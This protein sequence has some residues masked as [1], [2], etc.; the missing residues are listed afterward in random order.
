MPE[1]IGNENRERWILK[2]ISNSTLVIGDIPNFP[3]LFPNQ[4][5][6]LL[7]ISDRQSIL[8][9]QV[10]I[11][12]LKANYVT[13]NKVDD[14]VYEAVP[15]V[16]PEPYLDSIEKAEVQA[17]TNA[18]SRTETDALLANKSNVGHTHVHTD[19]T[20]FHTAVQT[21]RLDQFA[22]PVIAV[23]MNNQNLSGLAEPTQ[24]KDAAT[25][26]YVDSK[27]SGI[28]PKASCVA[29][30]TPA[31]GNITLANLQTIDGVSL[32]DTNRILVKDQNDPKENG[33]YVVVNGGPWYRSLDTDTDA[34]ITGMYTFITGGTTN[35]NSGWTLDTPNPVIGVSD[36]T[37]TQFSATENI[38]AGNGLQK[39][40]STLNVVGT[41]DRIVANA[42][43]VDISPNYS[44]QG[45]IITVGEITTG[46][47]SGSPILIDHGGTGGTEK[48]SA[49]VGIGAIFNNV[50]EISDT[51]YITNDQ[52]GKIF[53]TDCTAGPITIYLP[54]S[55]TAGN[56]WLT[57]FRKSDATTNAIT[58]TV[59]I[60]S[61]DTINGTSSTT[62]TYQNQTAT[63]VANGGDK[64]FVMQRGQKTPTPIGEGGTGSNL[65]ATGGTG[66]F[67]KQESTGANVTVD[68]IKNTE[69]PSNIDSAKIA[70]GT[71][72]NTEFQYINSLSSNAQTQ[73]NAKIEATNNL[74]SVQ[75]VIMVKKNPGTGEYSSIA[76]AITYSLTLTP[77]ES[78]PVVIFIGPGTYTEPALIIPDHVYLRGHSL[79]SVIIEPNASN[80]HVIDLQNAGGISFLT[81]KNAGSGYAGIHSHDA[82][83]FVLIHKVSIQNCDIGVQH[84]SDTQDSFLFL[85]YVDFTD[86]TTNTI[87]VKNLGSKTAFVNC[88]NLY[89][90][91]TTTDPADAI[92]IDGNMAEMNIQGCSAIGASVTGN[93]VRI[94]NGGYL[95]LTSA[96]IE[97]WG[98][99]FIIDDTAGSPYLKVQAADLDDNTYDIYVDHLTAL[100]YYAGVSDY[101][102]IYIKNGSTYFISGQENQTITVAKSGGQ[103]T[104]IKAAITSITDATTSKRYMIDVGPGIYTEDTITMKPYV[105]IYGRSYLATII[106]PTSVNQ[107][108]IIA[109]GNSYINKCL[110]RGTT[111]TNYS[112]IKFTTSGTFRVFDC[113]FGSSY[114]L[115]NQSFSGGGSNACS[116]IINRVSAETGLGSNICFNVASNGTANSVVLSLTD[117]Y[118]E[119]RGPSPFT[120][121][122]KATGTV[123]TVTMSGVSAFKSDNTGTGLWINNGATLICGE[124]LLRGFAKA[125]YSE[126]SGSAPSVQI[127]NI[128]LLVNTADIDIEHTGTTGSIFGTVD[129]DKCTIDSDTV[130]LLFLDPLHNGIYSVGSLY[131]GA[132]INQITDFL[133]IFENSASLGVLVGG[134]LSAGAGLTLNVTAGYGYL[135]IGDHPAEAT[136]P[137]DYIRYIS[138]TGSSIGLTASTTNYIYFNNAGT[139][140]KSNT[141]PNY[142]QN[143]LLGEVVTN[144]SSIVLIKKTKRY[145]IHHGNRLDEAWRQ[146]L[147]SVYVSGSTITAEASTRKLTIIGGEFYFGDLEFNPSGKAKDTNFTSYWRNG[148]G[149]WNTESTNAVDYTQYD[150]NDIS[151]NRTEISSSP[152]P[153]FAK[154]SLYV[155]MGETETYLLVYSQ[156]QYDSLA[157]ARVAALPTPPTY[158]NGSICLIASIIVEQGNT[159]IVEIRDNRPRMG[160]AP[161]SAGVVTVHNDLSGRDSS[162]AHEQYIL[163]SGDT[164]AGTLN[165]GTNAITNI[166]TLNGINISAHASRHLPNSGTDALTC[167][168]PTTDLSA[169]TTNAAG[170]ANS[171]SR[172]NHIHAI[173][174]TSSGTASTIV[175]LDAS[176]NFTA[177]IITANLS[178]T[179]TNATNVG[180]TND[181]ATATSVYP[182]WVTAN[183]GN[184]PAKTT[185]TKLSFV[186][187]T[188]VLTS[189]SFSGAGTGLTGTA[190]SLTA[191]T[192]TTNAN[193]TGDVTSVGNA[194][195]I[196]NLKVTNAMI[197]NSTIDLTAKVTGT[198][199]LANG[200]TNGT[201][202]STAMASLGT[203]RTITATAP[204]TIAGTT[205]ADLSA[206]RTIAITAATTGA[207]GSMSA[208]DKTKLDNYTQTSNVAGLG[209]ATANRIAYC[210]DALWSGGT[211]CWVVADG[212]NWRNPDGKIVSTALNTTL[213]LYKYL[214]GQVID[215]INTFSF[216]E[217]WVSSTAAG[218]RGWA[219]VVGSTATVSVTSAVASHPG[220]IQ[221]ALNNNVNS[222]CGVHLGSSSILLGN[223][224]TLV[225]MCLNILATPTVGND[226]ILRAGLGNNLTI[227]DHTDGVYFE[228]NRATSTTNWIRKSVKSGVGTTFFDTTI[229][230]ATGWVNLDI[231]I[232]ADAS[233]VDFY[234]NGVSAGSIATAN[235]PNVVPVG[236]SIKVSRVA[237]TSTPLQADYYRLR[238]IFTTAR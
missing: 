147:G 72:S 161:E 59:S 178:G 205:S 131:T 94:T 232:N 208:S 182:T 228:I 115:T 96:R 52:R 95:N 138:W 67:L 65:A 18:Y 167:A 214:A 12:L 13:L 128:A 127:S 174:T 44:G 14:N 120:N 153:Y 124:G 237:G 111:G 183:T 163:K 68:T 133:P 56:G 173:T 170:D 197:A 141:E 104:S 225:S 78:N 146:A 102:K 16:T 166:T 134:T 75:N 155:S 204:I 136:D 207:A 158:F 125:V 222:F 168:A 130:S 150:S 47:W 216:F 201:S 42:G 196:G 154:H 6:D 218:S 61:S 223:G 49:N 215:G 177:N 50:V 198:L 190:A 76:S 15:A 176:S 113:R 143:I 229:A 206:D 46:T 26:Q 145:G 139:L 64:Y 57:S 86:C 39:D 3:S 137:D 211:G 7:L 217:D 70:D 192:V 25:K 171:L 195:T 191:G 77:T 32:L 235:I 202:A 85:E 122:L 71:V 100:G 79:P 162:T 135:D 179:A 157:N 109:C 227:S 91:Y 151:G 118:F 35:A 236:P 181:A 144:G 129:P 27:A 21:T 107:D 203:G 126:F 199:P 2:N 11:D 10:L 51:T 89:L 116:L 33:V 99:A 185:S 5:I 83:N 156:G 187:S 148:S 231:L 233:N 210:S 90:E 106:Q 112:L 45:T 36:L 4:A 226:Y 8:Q 81:I 105:Y 140:S 29:A 238:Q 172:S 186:P 55:S 87:N 159:S 88:E 160:F 74:L 108:L 48:N 23:S 234:I 93:F 121:L 114:Y 69:L 149:G 28:S 19:V 80:H 62:L 31:I 110:L 194:T 132:K 219:T 43:N 180:I 188:G 221:F 22:A 34:E 164:M 193:L 1:N 200:G 220:I 117:V 175:A 184:L 84:L 60:G 63:L 82:G 30:S 98:K 9:S 103:F 24:T 213:S 66:Y 40:G 224:T 152:I 123:T 165:M 119:A 97:D 54:L 38:S 92:L 101:T 17:T 230:F 212:T 37:Y 73:L 142:L 53:N 41:T 169:A 20:D 189:T 209:T 58:I